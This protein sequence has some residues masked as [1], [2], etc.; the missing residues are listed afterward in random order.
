MGFIYKI[1]V[2]NELYIGSTKKNLLSQ[3]QGQHNYSLRNN[4][5]LPL[6]K[7]CKEN[8]IEK[9]I[10]EML[11]KVDNENIVIKE[12]EY[13]NKLNPTLN[14]NKAHSTK[15]DRKKTIHKSRE[16]YKDKYNEKKREHYN[17]NKNEINEKRKIKYNENKK[18]MLEKQKEKIK[19]DKCGVI[20][21]KRYLKNHQSRMS[22]RKM[23]DSSLL[24][25]DDEE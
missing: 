11:E 10:C 18:E 13:I 19:C 5:N 20:I 4:D 7:F 24:F 6:Y 22:C 16:K 21:T 25:T 3:R 14:T 15:E 12:Q 23:W 8:K 1:E 17:N 9:I 2:K